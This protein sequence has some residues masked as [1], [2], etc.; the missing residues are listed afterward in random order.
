MP[1]ITRSPLF[2]PNNVPR[3]AQRYWPRFDES[4]LGS[5][6]REL[7]AE[8]NRLNKRRHDYDDPD[9][10][11][12]SNL[13]LRDDGL[14]YAQQKEPADPGVAVYFKLRFWRNGKWYERPIVLSCDRWAKVA[15]NV[16]AIAYDIEAQRARERW[17]CTS[18]E[19]AFQGY[20][21]IPEKC[22]GKSWWDML[23]VAPGATKD[24]IEAAFKR[25][26]KSRHPD[27]GG[28]HDAWVEIRTAYDQAMAQFK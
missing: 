26:A 18:I 22:G 10:I 21:A 6:L 28:S 14:P 11:I 24:V 9:V 19:Q 7:L 3:T 1:E 2:W 23:G 17:G 12:S 20:V 8:I 5:A 4:P 16:K 15:L 13:I 25:L 27:V